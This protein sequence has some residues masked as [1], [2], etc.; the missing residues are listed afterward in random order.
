V[1]WEALERVSQAKAENSIALSSTHANVEDLARKVFI[2]EDEHAE[3]RRTWETSEREH[4]GCFKELT[5]L[6]TLGFELC[7]VIV[8]PPRARHLPEGMRPA[9]LC[10]T[11]MD[12][13]LARF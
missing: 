2:L 6:Q 4:Q 11:E 5:L 10:H 7:R 3:E 1:E 9:A 12:G 13:E 8:G